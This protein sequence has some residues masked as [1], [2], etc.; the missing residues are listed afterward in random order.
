MSLIFLSLCL[1]P[2]VDE[3]SKSVS[4]PVERAGKGERFAPQVRDSCAQSSVATFEN[5]GFSELFGHSVG[6]TFEA[7][8]VLER[9]LF[10]KRGIG[11]EAIGEN[12]VAFPGRWHLLPQVAR[13]LAI[14]RPQMESEDLQVMARERQPNPHGL[15]F[16]ED[17]VPSAQGAPASI[18][19]SSRPGCAGR[20]ASKG[21]NSSTFF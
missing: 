8:T 11:A 12:Q 1:V 16:G 14:T 19:T 9:P 20:V 17:K 10:K 4:Q 21:G 6:A 5:R 18:T 2:S 7:A 13:A 3:P 15:G